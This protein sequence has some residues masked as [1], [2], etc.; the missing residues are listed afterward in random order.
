MASTNTQYGRVSDKVIYWSATVYAV[1]CAFS[2]ASENFLL[3]GAPLAAAIVLLAIYRMDLMLLLCVVLTPFSLNLQHT[4]IGIGVS[5][6]S[7]PLMFGLF[8]IFLS[9]QLFFLDLDRKIL[10]HPASI[11][12]LIHLLW[13]LVSSLTSTMP[14]VSLKATLARACFVGIFFYLAVTLFKERNKINLFIWCYIVPLLGVVAYTTAT[15]AAAGFTEKA[16]HSAMTPFYNDHTAYAAVIAMFIPVMLGFIDDRTKSKQFRI[17]CFIALSAFVGAIVLSYTRA[18]WVSLVAAL[19]CYLVFALRIKTSIV[20]GAAIAFVALVLLNWTAIKM[21]LERNEEQSSTDYASH[22]QSV[23][24]ITTDASNVERINRWGCAIRMF[25]EKP[26]IGWGPGTY[27]FQ[28]A[29]FQKFSE[30]TIIST[31][32]GEGGNAHSEYIGALA[33]QGILGTFFF[34]LI[35]LT[36]VYRASRIIIHSEDRQVRLA[37]K[38]LVLGLV[39]YWVHGTLNNFLDT[40]KASVPYWG[41]IA[42]IV[43]LDIYHSRRAN[44]PEDKQLS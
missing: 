17:A 43:A 19:A 20:V 23:T 3:L 13:M 9:R 32:F 1:I 21:E 16:A 36:V 37:A 22:V 35:L 42:A 11:V 26:F 41:F 12:I 30:R 14:L 28:Y 27:M 31:N 34:I 5:L 25:A 6:P 4:S 15:H 38:G 39:T 44:K 7:E 2:I 8:L 24:N 18:A 29:P 40:E 33:E 10:L